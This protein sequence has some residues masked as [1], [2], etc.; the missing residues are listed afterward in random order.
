MS[1]DAD[2]PFDDAD[3]EYGMELQWTMPCLFAANFSSFAMLERGGFQLVVP[4]NSLI[5]RFWS[6]FE[7]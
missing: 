2:A 4:L 7:A 5:R 6:S 3:G 1:E